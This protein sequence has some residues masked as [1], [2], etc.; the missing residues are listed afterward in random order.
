[1]TTIMQ[2]VET[3][4]RESTEPLHVLEIVKRAGERLPCTSP[5][6]QNVVAKVLSMNIKNKGDKARFVRMK[7]GFYAIKVP[8]LKH[9]IELS[10]YDVRSAIEAWLKGRAATAALFKAEPPFDLIRCS[11]D[12]RDNGATATLTSENTPR[13]ARD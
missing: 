12:L 1:M 7:P 6:P 3:V 9:V 4:L 2:V 5:R 11:I 13:D 8:A 10:E